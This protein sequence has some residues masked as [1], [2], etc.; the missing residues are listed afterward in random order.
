MYFFDSILF[1]FLTF[2]QS[3]CFKF[4]S[5]FHGSMLN[6]TAKKRLD[7]TRKFQKGILTKNKKKLSFILESEPKHKLFIY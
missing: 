2:S 7:E 6:F 5:D 4:K 3:K 1:F